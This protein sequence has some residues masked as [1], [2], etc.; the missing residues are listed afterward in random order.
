RGCG[1]SSEDDYDPP[2]T[3]EAAAD[4]LATLVSTLAHCCTPCAVVGMGPLGLAVSLSYA[5]LVS[6]GGKTAHSE[7]TG[8]GAIPPPR[9]VMGI[10]PSPPLSP[11]LFPLPLPLPPSA[12]EGLSVAQQLQSSALAMLQSGEYGEHG[13]SGKAAKSG[14]SG[15]KSVTTPLMTASG[16]VSMCR[17]QLGETTVVRLETGGGD[18]DGGS[19]GI[20]IGGGGGGGGGGAGD[21]YSIAVK[22]LLR[23]ISP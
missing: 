15:A 17:Y 3:V 18:G 12:S 22:L 5:S 1:D 19:A 2:H 23:L 21:V 4:D 16:T 7:V 13:G 6:G 8:E 10:L 14:E 20:G 11:P 9:C